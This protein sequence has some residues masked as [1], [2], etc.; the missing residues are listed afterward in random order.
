MNDNHKMIGELQ[1][2][3]KLHIDLGYILLT[4]IFSFWK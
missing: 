1:S 4:P 3:V 2:F